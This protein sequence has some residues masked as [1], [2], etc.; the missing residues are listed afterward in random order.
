MKKT[1]ARPPIQKPKKLAKLHRKLPPAPQPY[2][3]LGKHRMYD[4]SG[5]G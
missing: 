3:K 2:N 1:P 4:G 5:D